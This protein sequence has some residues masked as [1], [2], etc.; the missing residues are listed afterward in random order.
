MIVESS[1]F[2]AIGDAINALMEGMRMIW[3]LSKYYSVE[4]K[5]ALLL[6][7]VAWQLC[8]NCRKNLSVKELFRYYK[9]INDQQKNV[10]FIKISNSFV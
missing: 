3:V 2:K 10:L 6:E 1:D 9:L 8:E 4:E 5:M 7:R